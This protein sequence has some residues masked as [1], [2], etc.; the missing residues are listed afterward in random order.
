MNLRNLIE[1]LREA[2]ELLTTKLDDKYVTLAKMSKGKL[3]PKSWPREMQ[4]IK[5][6]EKAGEE[7]TV[8]EKTSWSAKLFFVVQKA[9]L[10]PSSEPQTFGAKV[11][12]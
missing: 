10:A 12:W 11:R 2:T 8:I 7:W 5:A 4:A 3:V 9:S 6:A 1:E